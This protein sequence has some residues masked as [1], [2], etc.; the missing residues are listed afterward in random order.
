VIGLAEPGRYCTQI[1]I[2]H[3]EIG[4]DRQPDALMDVANIEPVLR[5]SQIVVSLG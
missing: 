1:I 5:I 2:V 3:A 4:L